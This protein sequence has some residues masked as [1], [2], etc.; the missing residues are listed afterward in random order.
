LAHSTDSRVLSR[1]P[2]FDDGVLD[3]A[4]A[5]VE[6]ARADELVHPFEGFFVVE[7]AIGLTLCSVLR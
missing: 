5:V 2:S 1:R 3:G 4:A 6:D 7:I